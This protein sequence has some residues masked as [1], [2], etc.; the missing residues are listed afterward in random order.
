MSIGVNIS[1]VYSYQ[2][3][4]CKISDRGYWVRLLCDSISLGFTV[5]MC[6]FSWEICAL[7]NAIQWHGG[8]SVCV[9]VC[10]VCVC[11]DGVCV[12]CVSVSVYL[13]VCCGGVCVCV[14]CVVC[15]VGPWV[16]FRVRVR[17]CVCV[18]VC[19]CVVCVC[20]W[21]CVCVCVLCVCVCVW[22]AGNRI[23]WEKLIL[24]I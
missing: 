21:C 1:H 7:I 16:R 8:N 22:R 17:G 15:V 9:C 5:I 11:V 13:C 23:I 12:L 18:C 19:V 6:G 3:Y 2:K 4:K 20:V 14:L 24:I 10:C